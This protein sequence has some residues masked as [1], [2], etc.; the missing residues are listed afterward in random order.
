M[1]LRFV[2]SDISLCPP[3]DKKFFHLFNQLY[4]MTQF[5][6]LRFLPVFLLT[7]LFST[8]CADVLETRTD[9][10]TNG[11]W[12]IQ[13]VNNPG[14][15]TETRD[16]YLALLGLI[17]T[18]Y[19]ED[20]TYDAIFPAGGFDDYSG[21]W[22]FNEDAS[23]LTIDKGTDDETVATIVDLSKE[24]LVYTFSDSLGTTELSFA[25]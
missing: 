5:L 14:F 12:K 9:H 2:E 1:P 13:D 17:E 6:R 21:T 10:L 15:D 7:L 20:G 11:A 19:L 22:D 23:V 24:I 18:S 16:F 4:S 3:S 8:G 25:H